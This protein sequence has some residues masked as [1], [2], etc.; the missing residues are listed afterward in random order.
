MV[1]EHPQQGAEALAAYL[2]TPGCGSGLKRLDISSTG[3]DLTALSMALCDPKCAHVPLESVSVGGS[4]LTADSTRAFASLLAAGSHAISAL[5]MSRVINHNENV[6]HLKKDS[7]AVETIVASLVLNPTLRTTSLR[8]AE[9][10]ITTGLARKL[11]SMCAMSTSL[12][13]LDVSD[14]DMGDAALALLCR[15]FAECR[16]P[17]LEVFRCGRNSKASDDSGGAGKWLARL[18]ERSH[19][20]RVLSVP[21]GRSGGHHL[22]PRAKQLWS[23]DLS[24]LFV[25]MQKK[26]Q[27]AGGEASG[28]A[29]GGA[30]KKDSADESA[31]LALEELDISCNGL[32]DSHMQSLQSA[33]RENTSLRKLA[34]QGNDT[35]FQCVRN[36]SHLL[37]VNGA[38]TD[39]GSFESSATDKSQH[40][41]DLIGRIRE[42]LTENAA[43][44]ARLK[45]VQSRSKNNN[46]KR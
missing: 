29:S 38:L 42:K 14:C 1:Y 46:K 9:N 20:L 36:F 22:N 2:S 15:G 45:R 31:P 21:G 40:T 12:I 44:L 23:I 37:H 6:R 18:V 17:R 13:S 10:H 41:R 5:N 3:S 33:L 19:H 28:G 26:Q 11:A 7:E 25:V 16:S 39:I 27:L 35:T 8:I 4:A 34:W 43:K 30:R 24:P 32:L